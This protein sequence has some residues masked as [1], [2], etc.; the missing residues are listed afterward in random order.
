MRQGMRRKVGH[1]IEAA[2]RDG[3]PLA[4]R[5][6]QEAQAKASVMLAAQNGSALALAKSTAKKL[7]PQRLIY[8]LL[9][10]LFGD[11]W[12]GR[13]TLFCR[14]YINAKYFS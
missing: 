14:W 11:R 2:Q 5:A 3:V 7:S 4:A 12:A 13:D 6:R 1:L 8:V 9:C 10:K